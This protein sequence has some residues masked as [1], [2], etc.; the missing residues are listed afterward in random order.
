MKINSKILSVPPYISTAWENVFSLQFDPPSSQLVVLLK[1][2]ARIFIP[3]LTRDQLDMIFSCHSEFLEKH[4]KSSLASLSGNTL[5]VGMIPGAVGIGELGRLTGVMQHD[6]SQKDAPP[7]PKE[8]LDKI[9]HLTNAMGISSET[10]RLLES[11]PHC[12]CPYCQLARAFS[13][14]HRESPEILPEE[15]ISSQELKFREWDI[16]QVG[17]K[18]YNVSNPFD[19]QEHYQVYL[20]NP[21]GCTCG[22]SKC[23][24]I[25]A[26]LHS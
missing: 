15:E 17:D 13:Q 3:H 9:S 22:K 21:V 12:N 10:F 1:N 11:E 26:V 5:S 2:G 8:V 23:E 18:L 4:S 16:E 14:E 6:P 24:H 7:I 19:K 20:G 25:V